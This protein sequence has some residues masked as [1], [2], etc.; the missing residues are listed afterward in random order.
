[1]PHEHLSPEDAQIS[2]SEWGPPPR[3]VRF[4]GVVD[5]WP[6]PAREVI[7]ALSSILLEGDVEERVRAHN[8]HG[9]WERRVLIDE[10]R[11]A[12]MK[13]KQIRF[14]FRHYGLKVPKGGLKNQKFS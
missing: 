3:S 13:N 5:S 6:E 14:V 2:G 12:N 1:M 4:V 7:A 11:K 10:L 8:E 9:E